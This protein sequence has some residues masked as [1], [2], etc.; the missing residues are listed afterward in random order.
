MS[1][2]LFAYIQ[3]NRNISLMPGLLPGQSESLSTHGR[4]QGDQ[5]VIGKAHLCDD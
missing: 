4:A 1:F 2:D 3:S 5:P